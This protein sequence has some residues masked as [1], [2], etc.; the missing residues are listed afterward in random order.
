MPPA[1]LPTINLDRLALLR[2]RAWAADVRDRQG[3]NVDVS[4]LVVEL[5]ELLCNLLDLRLGPPGIVADNARREVEQTAC[6]IVGLLVVL[7]TAGPG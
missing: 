5:A 6:L 3:P 4:P 1:G 2:A 7:G